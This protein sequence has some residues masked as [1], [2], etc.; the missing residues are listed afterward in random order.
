MVSSEAPG[1]GAVEVAGAD[2]HALAR[3]GVEAGALGHVLELP[4]AEVAVQGVGNALVDAGEAVDLAVRGR[5]DLVGGR[6]PERVVGDHQVE[7]AVPVVVEEGGAHREEVL[8]LL[9]EP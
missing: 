5:A 4:A 1:G 9:V 3:H 6:R 8:R 7:E 2:A